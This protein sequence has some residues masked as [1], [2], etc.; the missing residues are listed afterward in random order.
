MA[1]ADITLG[2]VP[3][4]IEVDTNYKTATKGNINTIG[5]LTNRS[6]EVVYIKYYIEDD[7]TVAAPATS[8]AQTN[9]GT[10]NLPQNVPVYVPRW[11]KKFTYKV[12]ANTAVLNWHP[13]DVGEVLAR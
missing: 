8:N 5:Y 2:M 12:A 13:A 6:S 10:F 7:A 3:A 11:V 9:D 1:S 4:T